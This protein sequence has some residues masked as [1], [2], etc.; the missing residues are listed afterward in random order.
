MVISAPCSSRLPQRLA[1]TA[2]PEAA[3]NHRSVVPRVNTD[4]LFLRPLLILSLSIAEDWLI[5]T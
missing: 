3:V 2:R 5:S 1:V 4:A